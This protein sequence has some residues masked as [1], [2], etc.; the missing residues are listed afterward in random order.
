MPCPSTW[1]ARWGSGKRDER[2][3]ADRSPHDPRSV[4]SFWRS[5]TPGTTAGEETNARLLP[6]LPRTLSASA[7][8]GAVVNVPPVLLET[9][10]PDVDGPGPPSI[11]TLWAWKKSPR[12]ARL[13]SSTVAKPMESKT[14][15]L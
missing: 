10:P 14:V 15:Q 5:L 7:A 4:S 6:G 12:Y 2:S 1:L 9:N 11:R 8:Y 13:P 3:F